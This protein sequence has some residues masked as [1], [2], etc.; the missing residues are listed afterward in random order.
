MH[1][2][3]L[4]HLDPILRSWRIFE[5]PQRG[6]WDVSRQHKHN[7]TWETKVGAKDLGMMKRISYWCLAIWSGEG[8]NATTKQNQETWRGEVTQAAMWAVQNVYNL[9]LKNFQRL[10]G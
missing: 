8:G 6:R 7:A 2:A 9:G 5:V 10:Y 4:Q 1:L 3:L